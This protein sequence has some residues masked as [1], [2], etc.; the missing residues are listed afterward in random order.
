MRRIISTVMTVAVCVS[1]VFAQPPA[2]SGEQQR[3]IKSLSQQEIDDY[4]SGAGMGFAKTAEL[5][6]YPGPRH[7]LELAEQ[8]NLTE[9]Q[10]SRS[11][12]LFEAM[13]SDAVRLGKAIVEQEHALNKLFAQHTINPKK[14]SEAIGHIAVLQG[15]LR[16]VHLSAH[17]E[18]QQ[19]LTTEQI[20][21]YDELRGYAARQ[22]SQG[23]EH[24]HKH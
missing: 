15:K 12:V 8:L 17:I 19:L 5:N 24:Q 20:E 7:V 2:Y 22:D 11:K 23:N 14:L 6:S 16:A 13:R 9:Q 10:A 4:L 18:M 21:K 3:A 1:A